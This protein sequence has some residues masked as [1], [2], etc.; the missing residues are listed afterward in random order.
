MGLPEPAKLGGGL[1]GAVWRA[2]Y[3]PGAVVTAVVTGTKGWGGRKR[4]GAGA[5]VRNYSIRSALDS[6]RKA[7]TLMKAFEPV[8]DKGRL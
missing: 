2:P 3:S 4:K 6:F 7:M 8:S 1:R 5:R